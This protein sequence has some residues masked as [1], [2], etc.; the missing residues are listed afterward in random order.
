MQLIKERSFQGLLGSGI[1]TMEG[2]HCFEQDNT[3]EGAG[4]R[5]SHSHSWNGRRLA[6]CFFF[7]LLLFFFSF[8]PRILRR[9]NS[10]ASNG[11]KSV[12]NI[13]CT[14]LM[15]SIFKHLLAH[16]YSFSSTF[17]LQPRVFPANTWGERYRL[18][19]WSVGREKKE[20]SSGVNKRPETSSIWN[21][22]VS[23]VSEVHFCWWLIYFN[24]RLSSGSRSVCPSVSRYR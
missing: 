24:G 6:R 10:K 23:S 9:K 8:I 18:W 7:L 14:Q 2:W 20:K 4:R 19:P 11:E 16:P 12:W 22:Y 15:A 21:S 17:S 13:H 1:I 3:G 5:R